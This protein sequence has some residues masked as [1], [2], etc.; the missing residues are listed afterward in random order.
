MRRLPPKKHPVENPSQGCH[1][2]LNSL[3]V[4]VRRWKYIFIE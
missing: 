4:H 2:F 1:D 3:L